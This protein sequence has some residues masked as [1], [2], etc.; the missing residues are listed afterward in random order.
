MSKPTTKKQNKSKNPS[1][2]PHWAGWDAY[3]RSEDGTANIASAIN[4]IA[5]VVNGRYSWNRRH[6]NLPEATNPIS[7]SVDATTLAVEMISLNT[8]LAQFIPE[9][10][11]KAVGD[12]DAAVALV[13]LRD[14]DEIPSE[15]DDVRSSVFAAIALMAHG[16]TQSRNS[17]T[18]GSDECDL[19]ETTMRAIADDSNPLSPEDIENAE[20]C[21]DGDTMG[22]ICNQYLI[23]SDFFF[24]FCTDSGA[25]DGT[26]YWTNEYVVRLMPHFSTGVE[27]GEFEE[28]ECDR[29]S[30][31]QSNCTCVYDEEEG[32]YITKEDAEEK[33]KVK[34]EADGDSET[35]ARRDGET[36]A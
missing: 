8:A 18:G 24:N 10:V 2:I 19:N 5:S 25:G 7:E 21:L 23:K 14:Q 31:V 27:E 34:A 30:Q 13:K 6:N 33:A 35:P 32:D 36:Q 16:I 3:F 4:G 12:M 22:A 26:G 15:A 9:S 28:Y 29:C 1:R 17:Y 11:R 20:F